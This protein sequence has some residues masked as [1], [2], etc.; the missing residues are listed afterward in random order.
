MNKE[1]LSEKIEYAKDLSFETIA[2]ESGTLF[3]KAWGQGVLG[4]LLIVLFSIVVGIVC[5]IP[6]TTTL[7]FLGITSDY[8]DFHLSNDERMRIVSYIF[9]GLFFVLVSAVFIAVSAAFC[10]ICKMKDHNKQGYY[11]YYYFLKR[12]Y[13]SKLFM[14]GALSAAIIVPSVYYLSYIPLVYLSVPIAFF[15]VILAFN[16]ELKAKEI[17]SLGF[18][19]GTE[20]WLLSIGFMLIVGFISM[21]AGVILCGF[22]FVFTMTLINL[23][24][25]FIYKHIIEFDDEKPIDSYQEK[26]D[27]IIQKLHDYKRP[28]KKR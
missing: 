10:R 26:T 2:S 14:L 22:G 21:I 4:S 13:F 12:K 5:F 3:T 11:D 1:L 19:L 16:P 27:L 6:Y 17:I 9:G 18:Q 28:I 23:P 7:V 15:I 24:L 20:K 8:T 25:Y